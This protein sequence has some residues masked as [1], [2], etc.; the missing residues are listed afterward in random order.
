MLAT[1]FI[2]KNG[3]NHL[4][5]EKH[6]HLRHQKVWLGLMRIQLRKT[7]VFDETLREKVYLYFSKSIYVYNFF[8]STGF[9]ENI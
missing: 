8:N 9:C 7:F 1:F 3:G 2:S 5:S 4:V 6:E